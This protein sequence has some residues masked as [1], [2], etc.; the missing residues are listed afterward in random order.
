M[1]ADNA[2]TS[3]QTKTMAS[4]K[5]IKKTKT[6]NRISI[7]EEET[8]SKPNREKKTARHT[9]PAKMLINDKSIESCVLPVLG[10]SVGNELR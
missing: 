10:S 5:V 2:P 8:E 9:C 1:H 3:S 4:S 7:K 6:I